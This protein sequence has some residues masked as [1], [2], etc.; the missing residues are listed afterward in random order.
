MPKRGNRSNEILIIPKALSTMLMAEK[1]VSGLNW[2]RV[3]SSN[4]QTINLDRLHSEMLFGSAI[5]FGMYWVSFLI[6]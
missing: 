5:S 6:M 1:A 4:S 3:L 2:N